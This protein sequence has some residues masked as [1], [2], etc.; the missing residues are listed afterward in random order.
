M[1]CQQC[2]LPKHS[3]VHQVP[4]Q[5]VPT[6]SALDYMIVIE[7]NMTAMGRG[8]SPETEA[9]L[10]EVLPG[11]RRWGEYPDEGGQS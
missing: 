1:N 5:F 6:V 9:M 3:A 10:N 8:P 7:R 2:G 4:H 11:R